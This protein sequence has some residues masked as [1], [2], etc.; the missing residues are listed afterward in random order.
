[1]RRA[2]LLVDAP[3]RGLALVAV[4]LMGT[5]ATVVHEAHHALEWADAQTSHVAD[6]HDAEG[7]RAQ[8]PCVG[9]DLHDADCAVCSG[10]SAATLSTTAA[11]VLVDDDDRQASARE[12]HADHRR[13]V[14]PARGP[15]AV[16]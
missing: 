7:D 5:G 1:M 15:P 16:A 11:P 2:P 9:G 12:A 6:L 8:A 3:L 10:L 4:L 13:A 14:A